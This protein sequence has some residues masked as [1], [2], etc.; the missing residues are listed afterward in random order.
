MDSRR[1]ICNAY[2]MPSRPACR[3]VLSSRTPDPPGEPTMSRALLSLTVLALVALPVAA[4]DKESKSPPDKLPK[5]GTV[6]AD[7]DRGEVILSAV[8]R[9]P[10]DKPCIGS[11]G[12]RIQAFVGC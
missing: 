3:L 5:Q 4:R 8:V 9:R 7:K 2:T 6:V 10:K 11:Y 1:S 12:Q